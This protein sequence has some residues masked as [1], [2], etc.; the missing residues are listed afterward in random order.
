MVMA[1]AETSRKYNLLQLKRASN[2]FHW[3]AGMLSLHPVAEFLV[4]YEKHPLLGCISYRG[5]T[6]CSSTILAARF[7]IT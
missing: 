2:G 7:S 5:A 4:I 3:I 6:G 1:R